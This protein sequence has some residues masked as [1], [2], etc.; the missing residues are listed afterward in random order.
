MTT[1]VTNNVTS[2]AEASHQAEELNVHFKKN[3]TLNRVWGILIEP[4]DIKK[5]NPNKQYMPQSAQSQ[6]VI[7]WPTLVPRL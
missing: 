3:K 2:F 7:D 6:S 5:K 1:N 4:I